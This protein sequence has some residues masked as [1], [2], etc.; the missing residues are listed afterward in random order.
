MSDTLTTHAR[1]LK[2]Y[3]DRHQYD[4]TDQGIVFPKA[5]LI[6][7]GEY[8]I[9][10]PGYEDSVEHNLIP[11]EG[12]N[13]ILMVALSNTAKLNSFYLALFSGNYTPVAG[14]TAANFAASATEI[15]SGTEGYTEATR[16]VWTP[17]AA[18][19]GAI[20]NL[21]SRANFTIATATN[22]TIRGAAL[23]S[24]NVKGSTTGVIISAARFAVDRIQYNTD[25]FTMGYRVN[26]QDV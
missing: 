16:P 23:L 2:G 20:D 1:E 10:S 19:S 3:M 12:M 8:H 22:I 9:S 11:T 7:R 25:V 6:A 26:L 5:G 24:S 14:L 17:A 18:A 15:V 4:V 21:A 13:H